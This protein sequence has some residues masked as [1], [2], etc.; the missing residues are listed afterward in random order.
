MSAVLREWLPLWLYLTPSYL[1]VGPNNFGR[2]EI[3]MA[4]RQ[5]EWDEDPETSDHEGIV[6]VAIVRIS[7]GIW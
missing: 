1:F 7:S 3:T 2:P 4:I 5:G 6:A